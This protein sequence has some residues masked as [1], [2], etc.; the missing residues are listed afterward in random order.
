MDA[1]A[2]P[3]CWGRVFAR[4]GGLACARLFFDYREPRMA[5]GEL[6]GNN[7]ISRIGL[8]RLIIRKTGTRVC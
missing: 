6:K 2:S 7:K 1:F 3:L 4:L 8:I 5:R